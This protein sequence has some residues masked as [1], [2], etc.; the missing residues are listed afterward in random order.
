MVITP[1]GKLLFTASDDCDLKCWSVNEDLLVKDFGK[2]HDDGIRCMM[3]TTNGAN[4]FTLCEDNILK[5]WD[6]KEMKLIKDYQEVHS[7]PVAS[8]AIIP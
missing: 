1:N 2:I 3:I 6:V 7:N 4:L 8:I 5:Q